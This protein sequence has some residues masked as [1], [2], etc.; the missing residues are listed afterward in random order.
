MAR[1]LSNAPRTSPRASSAA[2]LDRHADPS[3]RSTSVLRRIGIFGIVPIL[4]GVILQLLTLTLLALLWAQQNQYDGAGSNSGFIRTAWRAIAMNNYMT[5][6]VTISSAVIRF[7]VGPQPVVCT[8]LSAGLLLETTSTR[9]EDAPELSILRAYNN[10]PYSI[11][12]IA[13]LRLWALRRGLQPFRLSFQEALVT[14]LFVL[15]IAIQFSSTLLVSD[16]DDIVIESDPYSQRVAVVDL[17]GTFIAPNGLYM[18]TKTP[19][20]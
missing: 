16:L 7:L 10:G 18:W 13:L 11:V 19:A 17:S 4:G 9:F 20:I 1:P 3:S 6:I 5:L 2:S 15:G 12:E 14:L 8:A